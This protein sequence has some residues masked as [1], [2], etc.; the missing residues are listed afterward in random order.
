MD[1]EESL[2]EVAEA[3]AEREFER[4]DTLF[5]SGLTSGFDH[6]AAATARDSAE[7]ALSSIRSNLAESAIEIDQWQA[8]SLEAET[9]LREATTRRNAAEAVFNRMQGE[10]MDE[11]VVSPADGIIVAFGE[12]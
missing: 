2:A 4:Q 8:K 5:R 1:R 12:G 10:P 11:P 3:D 6:S 9:A 7:A